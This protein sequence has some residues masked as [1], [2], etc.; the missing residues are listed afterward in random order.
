MGGVSLVTRLFTLPDF[1]KA[2]RAG[3][4]L[5][6]AETWKRAQV[7]TGSLT[8]L[9]G[10]LAA[11]A[12]AYDYPVPLDEAQIAALVAGLAVLV[13]LFQSWAT[14]ATTRRVGLPP[15]ADA[16]GAGS[17]DAG[18]SRCVARPA[19]VPRRP[20]DADADLPVLSDPARLFPGG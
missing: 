17:A 6:H 18:G 5:A 8:A 9:L 12:R 3:Q 4:E 1:L 10:A 7:W 2:L 15:G 14:V 20:A 16:V 13:G 11:I 19:S